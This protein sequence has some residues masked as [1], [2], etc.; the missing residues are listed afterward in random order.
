MDFFRRIT[1]FFIFLCLIGVWD[2]HAQSATNQ[3]PAPQLAEVSIKSSGYNNSLARAGDSVYVNFSVSEP[4]N[5]MGIRVE[6]LGR[7]G[8]MSTNTAFQH[9]SY[10]IIVGDDTPEDI[11]GFTISNYMGFSGKTGEPVSEVTDG[12]SVTFVITKDIMMTIS[13]VA[14]TGGMVIP[15][16]FNKTNKGI[17]ITIPIPNDESVIN[18]SIT[19]LSKVNGNETG[20]MGTV[21]IDSSSIGK[22][23]II[24][25]LDNTDLN[26]LI[27]SFQ[28]GSEISFYGT[29][30]DVMGNVT[31]ISESVSKVI[32]DQSGPVI[33]SITIYST[34]EIATKAVADDTV[35][36]EFSVN[37]GIDTVG[38]MIGGNAIDGFEKIEGSRIRIWKKMMNNDREGIVAFMFAGGDKARNRGETITSVSDTSQVEFISA[39][40][41]I[42]SVNISSNSSFS[43]TLFSIGDSVYVEIQ[44][45]GPMIINDAMINNRM[46]SLVQ[47]EEHRYIF[48]IV[49]GDDTDSLANFSIA[50]TDENG[51]IYNNITATTDSSF[52]QLYEVIPVFPE[53]AISSSRGDSSVVVV[54]DT[55]YLTF[56]VQEAEFDSLLSIMYR[57]PQMID[58][59]GNGLY[60]AS[61]VLTEEDEEGV[62]NF[63]IQAVNMAGDTVGIDSTTNRSQL[64]YDLSPPVA[65]TL[66]EVLTSGGIVVAGFW[67]MSNQN[68]SVHIP[69][70]Y[71]YSLIDG[72]AQVLVQFDSTDTFA[73]IGNN[74]VITDT[75]I[76]DTFQVDI[77]KIEFE[78]MPSFRIGSNAIFTASIS[79]LAGNSTIG[80]PSLDRIQITDT[81]SIINNIAVTSS[82]KKNSKIAKTGDLISII[83]QAKEPVMRPVV[84]VAGDTAEVVGFGS[85]WFANKM[86]ESDDVQGKVSLFY[87]PLDMD[88]NPRGFYT[89]STDGSEVMFDDIA[90]VIDHLYEGSFT[91][92]RENILVADSLYLGMSVRDNASGI[93][94][95]SFAVGTTPKSGNV[96]PWASISGEGNMD[97]L[98]TGLSLENNVRYFA[99]AVAIDQV[100]NISDTLSGNGFMVNAISVNTGLATAPPPPT[101][102]EPKFKPTVA[103]LD[104]EGKGISVQEVQTL[105][106]RMR[107]EIGNTNAVR[108]I[109]RKAIESIMSEQGLA[110]SG[111]VSDECAAEVGELLGVQFMI[112]GIL[113]KMGDSYTIDAKMFSVETGETVEAV[114]TTY[115]GEI[116]GLL[117]EMQILS[118]EIVGL[119]VPPRLK[120]QRAG[121]TEKPTVAVLDFEGRGISI[122]ESQ[123]L[124]DRFTTELANT[125]RVRMVDRNTMTDVLV[126]QGFSSGECTSEECAAEVGAALG[127]EF[128]I[129]GTIGLIGN[130]Y[131][132]DCKMFSVATG[133]AESMKNV[134]YQGEVD[135]LITEMEILAWDI[136]DIPIPSKLKQKRQMGMAAFMENQ[137]FAPPKTK[138]QS[139]LRSAAFPG[140]GQ[141]YND[142]KLEGYVFAGSAAL[143]GALAMTSN[144]GFTKAQTEFNTNLDLYNTA[145]NVDDIASYRAKVEQADQDMSSKNTNLMIFSGLYIGL[146]VGNMV[147]AYLTWDGDEEA[148]LPIRLA[149]DPN[150]HMALLRWEFEL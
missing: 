83:L 42:L 92:D 6:I 49:V 86:L 141:L 36:V 55:I 111:C 30:T 41:S 150:H 16:F 72:N 114:N 130:T 148:S 143:F 65:F 28:E 144:S 3:I 89:S 147:H 19:I 46:A 102:E 57:A 134:S 67:N 44:M 52:L 43:D 51:L 120:L 12:S 115:E 32:V 27:S 56:R 20:P 138:I 84:L 76:G 61:Y 33:D 10:Y 128:M 119:D 146:W 91:E 132:I 35:Y 26:P 31:P 22:D 71:D 78:S 63:Q 82:N 66:A 45:D 62:V 75:T 14:A 60:R 105:T 24:A 25:A 108:L 129:N 74:I 100:G 123:T 109:E 98:L 99:S 93:A 54:N 125:D 131:T 101:V 69:I 104:F 58:S 140:L 88:G 95:F 94:E 5:P 116:Q 47:L 124:T 133:A 81:T 53:V 64:V 79:D 68:L 121:E 1:K 122:L 137:A 29:V 117:L 21:I 135:G 48:S 50:F 85:N 126:E 112:N 80:T 9:F 106:E 15:P 11:I 118:W 8:A 107:T 139:L 34:N 18:S 145:S 17:E 2:L 97:T 136:L 23:K 39:G 7:D 127:V 77:G 113:G 59:I 110:Q 103:I 90:P 73:P 13:N 40:L 38:G 70:D 37:E 96:V 4:V 142:K 87:A 149:Y